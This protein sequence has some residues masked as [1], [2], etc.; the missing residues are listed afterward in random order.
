MI[1]IR[2]VEDVTPNSIQCIGGQHCLP[3]ISK[4]EALHSNTFP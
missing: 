1:V 4:T 3:V 2:C